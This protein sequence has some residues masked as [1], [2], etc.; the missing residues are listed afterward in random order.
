[1]ENILPYNQAYYIILCSD[2]HFYYGNIR[3]FVNNIFRVQT[4][5]INIFWQMVNKTAD[6]FNY[7]VFISFVKIDQPFCLFYLFCRCWHLSCQIL[8]KSVRKIFIWSLNILSQCCIWISSQYYNNLLFCWTIIN[9]ILMW[10]IVLNIGVYCY[11]C[12]KNACLNMAH[13]LL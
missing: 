6:C 9:W 4:E 11:L 10:N 13:R 2:T 7:I 1:M 12:N 5:N 3:L 8:I